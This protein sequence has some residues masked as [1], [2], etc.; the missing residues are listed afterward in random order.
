[1]LKW[2][3]CRKLAKMGKLH[4]FLDPTGARVA[5]CDGLL[6]LECSLNWMDIDPERCVTYVFHNN[7]KLIGYKGLN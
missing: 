5:P 3:S 1:M 4:A 6:H 7:P 2:D